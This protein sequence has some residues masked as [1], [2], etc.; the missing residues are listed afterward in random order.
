MV[1]SIDQL[2]IDVFKVVGGW[3]KDAPTHDFA[4]AGRQYKVDS[5]IA[6][7]VVIEIASVIRRIAFVLF[8][9]LALQLARFD[10]SFAFWDKVRSDAFRGK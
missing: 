5:Q 6:C 1:G 4:I 10:A 8:V 9:C 7:A 2:G 3:P